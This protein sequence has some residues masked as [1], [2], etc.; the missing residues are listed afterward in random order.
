ML[1]FLN[2]QH[3]R[4]SNK[5]VDF[6]IWSTAEIT[7]NGELVRAGTYILTVNMLYGKFRKEENYIRITEFLRNIRSQNACTLVR[8]AV[9]RRTEFCPL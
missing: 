6:I 4:V 1:P 8:Q 3:P 5:R 7:F 9:R 2:R